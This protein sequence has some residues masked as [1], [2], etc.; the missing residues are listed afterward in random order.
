MLRST[1][2]TFHIA[3]YSHCVKQIRTRGREV[4]TD[5][6]QELQTVANMQF[7]NICHIYGGCIVSEKEIWLVLELA[8]GNLHDFLS[9]KRL[10]P[11]QQISFALQ[12]TQSVEY[13]HNLPSPVIHSDITSRSLL[14]QNNTK[15]LL[16]GFGLSK[17]FSSVSLQ[18]ETFGTL[19]WSPP[20]VVNY[21]KVWSEK[22][23]I[24]SLGMVFYE[25]VSGKVPYQEEDW[26][27]DKIMN[28]IKNGT[29]PK[30]PK[31][32][33]KVILYMFSFFF[34]STIYFHFHFSLLLFAFVFFRFSVFSFCFAF[35]L[36]LSIF[37]FR[38][39]HFGAKRENN[40]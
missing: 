13:I 31:E 40:F 32:C 33:P 20:E 30:L 25:M 2:H 34:F 23:D 5:I 19:R 18:T 17:A 21:T 16:T 37:T 4:L 6:C 22:S 1:L 3:F 29:R 15:I 12:A 35:R 36:S 14:V 9:S 38:V 27:F 24:Y 28:K 26:N 39:L 10:T 8:D 7:P 11:T